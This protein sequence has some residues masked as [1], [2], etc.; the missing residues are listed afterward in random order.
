MTRVDISYKRPVILYA[1][2]AA[3][4]TAAAVVYLNRQERIR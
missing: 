1:I 3:T 4:I 2:A